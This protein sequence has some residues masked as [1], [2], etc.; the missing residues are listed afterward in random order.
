MDRCKLQWHLEILKSN[1]STKLGLIGAGAWGSNYIK[2]I[3]KIDGIELIGISTKSGI[4]KNDFLDYIY[5][6]FLIGIAIHLCAD[7]FPKAY[8]GNA[9]I[10]LPFN[11]NLSKDF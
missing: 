4:I 7:L 9:L 6:G 2:T 1:Y 5:I 10:K 8:W 3:E 11:I